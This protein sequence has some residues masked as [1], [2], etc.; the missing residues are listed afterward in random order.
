M[1][2]GGTL[3]SVIVSEL[4]PEEGPLE[5]GCL[6]TRAWGDHV[7]EHDTPTKGCKCGIHAYTSMPANIWTSWADDEPAMQKALN[8]R[9]GRIEK[10]ARGGLKMLV[11]GLSY[12]WGKVLMGDNGL[13]AQFSYPAALGWSLSWGADKCMLIA[14]IAENYRIPTYEISKLE[15]AAS[16][17]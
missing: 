8:S 16:T 5:A 4:W 15:E 10:S 3:E 13:R 14:E 7:Q 11:P 6:I 17:T 9:Q 2:E 1:N 12:S